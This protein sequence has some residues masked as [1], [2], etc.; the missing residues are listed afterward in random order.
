MLDLNVT[1]NVT[2]QDF[3]AVAIAAK[4]SAIPL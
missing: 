1:S 2:A 3:T 4:P